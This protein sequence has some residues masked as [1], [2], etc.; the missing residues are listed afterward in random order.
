MKAENASGVFEQIALS[1]P[2]KL[3]NGTVYIPAEA[4]S[5][6]T[7]IAYRTAG[8]G[9]VLYGDGALLEQSGVSEEDIAQ[10]DALF[11]TEF[12]ANAVMKRFYVDPGER[13]RL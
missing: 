1:A 6:A 7:G 11:A 2:V 3:Q 13:T 4:F 12:D 9:Y 5:A 8:E 10:L